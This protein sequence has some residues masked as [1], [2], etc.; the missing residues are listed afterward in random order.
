ML[1]SDSRNLEHVK[2]NPIEILMPQ[3]TTI[4]QTKFVRVDFCIH[5]MVSTKRK[6]R[7]IFNNNVAIVLKIQQWYEKCV[8]RYD[9]SDFQQINLIDEREEEYNPDE[10]FGDLFHIH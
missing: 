1:F 3:V 7:F 5:T 8:A 10:E 4:F 2:F 9:K 6:Y